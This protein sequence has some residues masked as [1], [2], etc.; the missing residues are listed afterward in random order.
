MILTTF[1]KH[2]LLF[3]IVLLKNPQ[4]IFALNEHRSNKANLNKVIKNLKIAAF[5]QVVTIGDCCLTKMRVLSFLR[6]KNSKIENP[7][8]LFDWML[9]KN[10]SSLGEALKNDFNDSFNYE[11][12]NV[13]RFGIPIVF[14]SKYNF[15]F[16]HVYDHL[17]DTEKQKV[18]NETFKIYFNLI[19]DKFEHLTRNSQKSFIN[20]H[21]TT[22]YLAYSPAIT[23]ELQLDIANFLKAIKSKR[24]SNF[25]LLVLGRG[26]D[27]ELI[28]EFDKL[29]DENLI[30]HNITLDHNEQWNS[31]N[32]VKE[33]NQILNEFLFK[34]NK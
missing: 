25:V 31:E 26:K 24:N 12:L 34:E 17:S 29:I 16:S 33:W 19:K 4:Y 9:I 32:T 13:V 8:H 10:Y 3:L 23:N 22:L 21:K 14:N 11:S 20:N 18:S 1:F 15:I 30:F 6:D 27:N 28:Y 2:I 7:N 5:E